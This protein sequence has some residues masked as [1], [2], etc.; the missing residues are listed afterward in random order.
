MVL[1]GVKIHP[2]EGKD[3]EETQG[4]EYL[5]RALFMI[6]ELGKGIEGVGN[7][8]EVGREMK[9]AC[10]EKVNRSEDSNEQAIYYEQENGIVTSDQSHKC[11]LLLVLIL[12]KGI[13]AMDEHMIL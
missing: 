11:K 6:H 10:R 13:N 9:V 5:A 12:N 8:P 1:Y 4:P 3:W 2:N 7:I